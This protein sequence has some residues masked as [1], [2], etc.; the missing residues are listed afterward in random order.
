MRLIL[1]RHG[2]AEHTPH[3][4]YAGS[5]TDSDLIPEGEREATEVAAALASMGAGT[6]WSGPLLRQRKTARTVA[7]MMGAEHEIS[8]AL[9]EL[10]FGSWEGR[11]KE[12]ISSMY[13]EELKVWDQRSAWPEGHFVGTPE[14]RL[15]AFDR[16][17]EEVKNRGGDAVAVTSNG[18]LRLLGKR[19]LG[20]MKGPYGVWTGHC[21]ELEV[22]DDV[23][24]RRW[25]AHPRDI[26]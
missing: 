22:G 17:L 8:D 7:D 14:E 6:V 21:C 10:D 4:R 24:V 20:E 16:W 19:Y 25:N 11:T 13:P 5:G 23:E 2:A 12:E 26:A 9:S 1:V 3:G 18:L 15:D